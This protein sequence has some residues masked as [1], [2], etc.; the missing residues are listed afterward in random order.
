MAIPSRC[1]RGLIWLLTV[2]VVFSATAI[3]QADNSYQ[4]TI[5][6]NP[7]QAKIEIL[8]ISEE[9]QP[10]MKLK[11]GRYH[12]VVSQ[13]GFKSEKG[14][15]DIGTQDWVGKVVLIPLKESV[16][17]VP[18]QTDS[19]KTDSSQTD[20][21]QT[22]FSQTDSSQAMNHERARLAKEWDLLGEEKSKLERL[23]RALAR[24][25]DEVDREKREIKSLRQQD[26]GCREQKVVSQS[27]SVVQKP[28]QSSV[29]NTTVPDSTIPKSVVPD[30]I[31]GAKE[32][33]KVSK[34]VIAHSDT[35]KVLKGVLLP[36]NPAPLQK[37]GSNNKKLSQWLVDA[38]YYLKQVRHSGSPPPPEGEEAFIKLR[39]AQKMDPGNKKVKKFLKLYKVRYLLYAGLFQDK[40]RANKVIKRITNLGLPAFLQPIDIKGK[41]MLR[42]CVGLFQSRKQVERA[43]NLIKKKLSMK[44]SI[45]RIYRK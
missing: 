18:K 6:A 26:H 39:K 11:P 37:K 42:A 8:N 31:N 41:P 38:N 28:T 23:R 27:Q 17:I 22:D 25:K 36:P 4:L 30:S 15:I 44:D 3:S 24:E 5:L 9:Y 32:E 20:F 33:S 1:T 21:S 29:F 2:L 16:K 7:E 45:L 35:E 13:P 10:G 12:I 14:F 19:T 43:Q 34:S 40:K